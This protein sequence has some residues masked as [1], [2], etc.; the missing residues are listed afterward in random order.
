VTRRVV[1]D[2]R[3]WSNAEADR[4]E[5][6]DY[7]PTWPV[8]F[9][10]EADRLAGAL[11]GITA[12]AIEHFGSTAV[13]GL[14]AKPIIDIMLIVAD[15]AAWPRLVAPIESLGYAY[16]AENP[17]TDRLF[18]VRGMPPFGSG[19]THHVHVRA[20]RDCADELRF[21]DYLRRHREVAVAYEA[22]KR[23]LAA[24][25]ACDREA[26]GAAKGEFVAA[27]LARAER[28]RAPRPT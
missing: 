24:R 15:G 9:A 10:A 6:C 5:I 21:R 26:Y 16:W 28:E 18:F 22:L 8:R 25:H 1:H 3:G 14:A 7:D 2:G 12:C 20:P 17:R 23:A 19:R 27:T 4:I 13:P 11:G